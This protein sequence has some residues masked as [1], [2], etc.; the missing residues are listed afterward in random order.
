MTTA[1]TRAAKTR[2]ACVSL[3]PDVHGIAARIEAVEEEATMKGKPVDWKAFFW[4]NRYEP[5]HGSVKADI[6][7]AEESAKKRG[8]V[9]RG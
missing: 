6:R 5:K 3:T 4:A 2:T 8:E 1:T 7:H 9:S